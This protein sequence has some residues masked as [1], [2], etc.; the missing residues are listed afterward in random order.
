MEKPR[1][2]PNEQSIH[3]NDTQYFNPVPQAVWDFYIGGYQVIAKY[4]KSRAG[5]TLSLDEIEH[6]AK[7][8]DC[9]AFTIDQMHRI[10]AAYLTA[11][12]SSG[13]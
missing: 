12:A 11:F 5:R 4:L 1:Y 8:A 7:V 10:D 3:I 13:K 6:V 2:S 9:L